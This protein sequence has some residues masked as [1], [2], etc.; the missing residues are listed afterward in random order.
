MAAEAQGMNNLPKVVMQ[1]YPGGMYFLVIV[2]SR[3][4]ARLQ[5]AWSLL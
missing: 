1:L 2:S 4:L 3:M 5:S